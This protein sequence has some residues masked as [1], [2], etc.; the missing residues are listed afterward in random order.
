M[1]YFVSFY[2][3]RKMRI[4]IFSRKGKFQIIKS[5]LAILAFLIIFA[6]FAVS[7]SGQQVSGKVSA[8]KNIP[9]RNVNVKSVK[10]GNSVVTD[11]L[12]RYS[13]VVADEDILNFIASGFVERKIRLKKNPIVD[14]NLKYMFSE[15]SFND[16]VGNNHISAK[17]LKKTLEKYPSKG[18]KDYSHYQNIYELIRSE[19]TNVRVDGTAVYSVKVISFSLSSQVLYVVDGTVI[20]DISFISPV[21]VKKIEY[22][23]D[24]NAADY[25][26]R[27][28]NGVIK[29]TLK[30]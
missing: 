7:I 5:N 8:F 19:I 16:A 22:L 23:E 12:G 30:K 26:M 6:G 15:T 21:N 3:W 4:R 2:K 29:I 11:S 28:A 25:G 17:E 20:S 18:E 13:I 1:T 9:L 14:V 24:M 10:T 27:G